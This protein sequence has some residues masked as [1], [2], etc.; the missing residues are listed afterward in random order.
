MTA[1]D[2]SEY[3]GISTD[4]LLEIGKLVVAAGRI[5][6]LTA[7]IATQLNVQHPNVT[8]RCRKIQE[9]CGQAT[10]DTVPPSPQGLADWCDR[11]IQVMAER[12]ERI[13]SAF[14]HVWDGEQWQHM[15]IRE[16]T[17]E[18][19]PVSAGLFTGIRQEL[20]SLVTEGSSRLVAVQA[21]ES[22]LPATPIIQ[23]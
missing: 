11:V 10:S 19:L 12:N 7:R 8:Q 17:E 16:R 5:E 23:S 9:A 6:A 18:M 13:H 20:E 2:E 21:R 15:L 14:A 1:S 4:V 3:C 22:G